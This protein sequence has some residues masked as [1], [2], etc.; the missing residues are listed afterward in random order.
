MTPING[1]FRIELFGLYFRG[2]RKAEGSRREP[3]LSLETMGA[4]CSGP[5]GTDTRKTTALSKAFFDDEEDAEPENVD[6]YYRGPLIVM[7]NTVTVLPGWREW[8]GSLSAKVKCWCEDS[9]TGELRGRAVEWA[10]HEVVA[11]QAI[12][13]NRPQSLDVLREENLVVRFKVL[14]SSSGSR[15]VPAGS[16]T[17]TGSVLLDSVPL[18]LQEE[19]TAVLTD[20]PPGTKATV[21]SVNEALLHGERWGEVSLRFLPEP[22]R[23]KTLFLVRH[24]ESAWNEA[25][26]NKNLLKMMGQVDH[27]LTVA[28]A[29]QVRKLQRKVAAW[30]LTLEQE[31]RVEAEQASV[32]LEE[33]G[34]QEAHAK[35]LA[36]RFASQAA[37]RARAAAGARAERGASGGATK[38]KMA[39]GGG[40]P[41]AARGGLDRSHGSKKEGEKDKKDKKD[42]AKG[43]IQSKQKDSKG[44]EKPPAKNK[45]AKRNRDKGGGVG[46][47]GGG[48]GGGEEEKEEVVE[49]SEVLG[50]SLSC[51]RHCLSLLKAEARLALSQG[52]GE[53]AVE[54]SPDVSNA[55]QAVAMLVEAAKERDAKDAAAAH[56]QKLKHLSGGLIGTAAAA[57][58]ASGSVTAAARVAIESSDASPFDSEA[59]GAALPS[60]TAHLERKFMFARVGCVLG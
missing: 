35:E 33:E 40:A 42:K 7:Y 58:D 8:G 3:T 44:V 1:I 39:W 32:R 4:A 41:V 45:E 54:L 26:R 50:S 22:P 29:Q 43:S 49:E 28:G 21:Q 15:D 57:A 24:A 20:V 17:V 51:A 52:D 11:G 2:F 59:V 36:Q 31:A 18:E 47:K 12:V 60:L 13:V 10:P 34:R 25:Q 5:V 37:A 48:K 6:I 14:I 23:V 9:A 46:G 55:R 16:V 27:P 56:R 30:A 53:V 19:R 38:K